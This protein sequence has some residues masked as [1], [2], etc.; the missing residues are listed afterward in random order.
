M[1]GASRG[2]GPRTGKA[3]RRQGILDALSA[4]PAVR[5]AELA[6]RFG[7]TAETVRRDLDSLSRDGLVARTYGGAAPAT[8]AREPS[9]DER[10]GLLVAERR[11]IAYAALDGV[12]DGQV[13]MI[14]SGATTAQFAQVLASER[15]ALT[16]ITNGTGIAAA[17]ARNPDFRVLLCPG[18]YDAGECGTYGPEAAAFLGQFRADRAFLGAGG[19]TAEG[20]NDVSAS[21]C[22]LKRAM[23]ER[24]GATTLLVDHTKIERV[25]LQRICPLGALARVVTDRPLPAALARALA[26]AGV[27]VTRA[28]EAAPAGAPA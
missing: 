27:A 17:L 2:T 12:E 22:W 23:I 24:A 16:V 7:V 6:R 15:R 3:E 25:G 18:E 26:E 13:L 9:L 28:P 1:S 20:P 4:N 10:H 11:R 8:L 14:D 19:L 5:I 21:L